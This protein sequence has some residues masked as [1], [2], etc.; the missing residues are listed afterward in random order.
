MNSTDKNSGKLDIAI[1]R[2]WYRVFDNK[3]ANKPGKPFLRII[4]WAKVGY[5][6]RLEALNAF[7]YLIFLL[8]V[9][10]QLLNDFP[11]VVES[12]AEGA[13]AGV[14][15]AKAYG[16]L[17]LS[18]PD[19]GQFTWHVRAYVG[20]IFVAIGHIFFYSFAPYVFRKHSSSMALE[21]HLSI[22]NKVVGDE[23][24]PTVR[25]LWERAS[26]QRRVACLTT[27]LFYGLGAIILAVYSFRG[28]HLVWSQ[29]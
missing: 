17:R 7:F 25:K 24:S 6:G 23:P 1:S 15:Q 19:T 5:V 9:G 16:Y 8:P 28:A 13:V 4:N 26:Y 10:I 14:V 29:I 21:D 22:T 12:T 2:L 3:L 27:A 20:V 18:I 11:I